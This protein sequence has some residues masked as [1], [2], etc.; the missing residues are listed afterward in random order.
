MVVV[1]AGALGSTGVLL[2]SRERGLSIADP[3]GTRFSGNGDFFSLTYNSNIQINCLGWGAHPDSD[4]AR[5]MQPTPDVRLNPGPT[6]VAHLKFNRSAPLKQ[7]MK[8]DD[9]SIPLLYVDAAR[10]ALAL[11]AGRGEDRVKA[12]RWDRDF[13]EATDLESGATN[14]SLVYLVNGHDPADG[15]IKLDPITKQPVIDWPGAGSA[16]VFEAANQI[17]RQHAE[18]L[19]G[20]FVENPVWAISPAKTLVT[21]HPLG[22]CPMGEDHVSGVVNHLGQVFDAGGNLHPGLYV[23]DASIIPTSLGVNPFLTISALAERR[24]EA[25]VRQL[26]GTARLF[27][28]SPV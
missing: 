9:L 17:L 24:A 16:P 2:R 5:R 11:T 1:A 26:G 3:L 18:A 7:R 12:A 8:S 22:G 25:L 23:A 20:K 13:K 4:R 15:K 19:G 27:P 21:A 10:F 28:S 6:I 14:F